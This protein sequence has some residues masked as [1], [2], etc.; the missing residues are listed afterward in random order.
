MRVKM[1]SKGQVVLP[2]EVRR[3]YRLDAGAELELVDAGDH[4]VVWPA[5]VDPVGRLKGLLAAMPG[6]RSLVE[7]LLAS[8]RAD[9][10]RE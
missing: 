8:R 6:E 10:G 4:L 3:K 2:A 7:A 9:V 1:S 5:A